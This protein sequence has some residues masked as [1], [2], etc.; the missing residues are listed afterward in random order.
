M[1]ST[2]REAQGELQI[3]VTH[4]LIA[5]DLRSTADLALRRAA[6]LAR[7]HNARLTLL[8][9][10][11]SQLSSR[12][13]DV[14]KQ[15]L[16]VSLTQYAPPDTQLLILNGQPAE[17]ILEQIQEQQADLLVLGAQHHRHPLFSGTTLD[18]IARHCSIPLLLV[19][20]EDARPYPSAL[21]ALDFSIWACGALAKVYQLLPPT[22]TLHALNVFEP[23]KNASGDTKM[24]LAIQRQLVAQLLNDE[25]QRLPEGG[26]SLTHEVLTGRILTTLQEQIHLRQPPLLVIGNRGR[27]AL[28]SALLGD[29][30]QYFLHKAPCDVLVAQ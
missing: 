24:E 30:V 18:H 17:V 2:A 15:A 6:Q 10:I 19:T 16:D 12:E 7:Q 3:M 26:P 1:V 9:V 11:N 23:E 22:A 27:G 20:N 21:V 29:L 25:L 8:H 28:A 13:L 4:I 5:H 14:V